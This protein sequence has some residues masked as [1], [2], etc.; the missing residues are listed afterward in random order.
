LPET[1]AKA[2]IS[3]IIQTGG[4]IMDEEVIKE[5]DRRKM[6]MVMTGVRHFKH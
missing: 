4:S 1:P 6:V 3:A 2:G 5:A